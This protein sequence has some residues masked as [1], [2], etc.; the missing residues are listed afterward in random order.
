MFLKTTLLSSLLLLSF[1][2]NAQPE[3]SERW[4]EVKR[5]D[6]NDKPVAFD[7]TMHLNNVTKTSL[8][9]RRGSFEY[10]GIIS[11][12]LLEVGEDQYQVIKQD[13]T[14]IHIGDETYIH[15]FARQPKDRSAADASASLID[16][17]MP[18]KPVNTID[19][20]LLTGEWEAYNRKRKDGGKGKINYKTLIKTISFR[21][22][23]PENN[24][25]FVSA[26]NGTGKYAIKALKGGEIIITDEKGAQHH[27]TVWKL[28]KDELILEDEDGI[29]Y[30]MK[31]F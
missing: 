8:K 16:R 17:T 21:A 4:K 7:D 24:R 25:G 22:D 26:N 23:A 14:T 2:V 31:Q 20:A 3:Y 11:N 1:S 10:P 18:A 13:E 5:T 15:V 19:A 28:T 9:M 12:D 30:F 27:I 6:R 29:L